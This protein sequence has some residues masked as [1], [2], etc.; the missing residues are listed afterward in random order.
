MN[1]TNINEKEKQSQP[2]KKN[3]ERKKKFLKILRNKTNGNKNRK[4]TRMINVGEI[5][6]F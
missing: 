1:T 6:V 4:K 2:E 3:V 5:Q